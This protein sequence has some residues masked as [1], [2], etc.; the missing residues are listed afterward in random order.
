[1]EIT[2]EGYFNRIDPRKNIR[3]INMEDEF[4]TKLENCEKN[5]GFKDDFLSPILPNGIKIKHD[6]Q[7]LVYDIDNKPTSTSMLIGQKVKAVV[8]VKKYRFCIPKSENYLIGWNVKLVK[9]NAI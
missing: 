2:V 8:K 9:M 4:K 5:M 6:K 1:M 7:A 3:I